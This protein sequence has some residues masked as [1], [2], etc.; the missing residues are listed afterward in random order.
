MYQQWYMKKNVHSKKSKSR[1]TCYLL[2]CKGYQPSF[3]NSPE[4]AGD[5]LIYRSK[6]E[7][8]H[9]QCVLLAFRRSLVR[10]SSHVTVSLVIW[11][12]LLSFHGAI[13]GAQVHSTLC[14]VGVRPVNWIYTVSDAIVLSWLWLTATRSSPLGDYS[15]LLKVVDNW[16]HSVVVDSPLDGF[17][18]IED[19]T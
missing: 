13:R 12:H 7:W 3:S 18:Q 19:L 14:R 11:S 15:R 1:T 5:F 8:H 16:P 2:I 10:R 9:R 4:G 6:T 17:W